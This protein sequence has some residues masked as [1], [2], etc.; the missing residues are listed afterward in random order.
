MKFTSVTALLLAA[1][2]RP[3]SGQEDWLDESC[4][5]VAHTCKIEGIP[6]KD[7]LQKDDECPTRAEKIMK[8][9]YFSVWVK[10]TSGKSNDMSLSNDKSQL[11]IKGPGFNDSFNQ[12]DGE[13]AGLYIDSLGDSAT[14]TL[15]NDDK[16]FFE[17]TDFNVDVCQPFFNYEIDVGELGGCRGFAFE[18]NMIRRCRIKTEID[19]VVPTENGD[20]LC[21]DYD[22]AEY[23]NEACSKEI[24]ITYWFKNTENIAVDFDLDNS[25]ALYGETEVDNNDDY[26]T[27]IQAKTDRTI[28]I[29]KQMDVC[30]GVLPDLTLDIVG[31]ADGITVVPYQP[32]DAGEFYGSIDFGE[33]EFD[34]APTPT[35]PT[36]PAPAPP[37]PPA[38]APPAP[39]PPAPAPPAPAPPAPAT[40]GKGH[41]KRSGKAGNYDDDRKRRLR[42]GRN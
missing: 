38:P 29:Y 33:F 23:Q 36:P 37:A 20:V 15:E 40:P 2:A 26:F 32:C 16:L 13:D 11:M 18:K 9:M 8:P 1:A 17:Y 14:D 30:S 21:E 4:L 22:S 41:G 24:E 10:N 5:T 34:P 6:C 39:A 27:R 3:I 28:T 7:Y 19:C 12:E 42:R 25:F 31:T 35:P